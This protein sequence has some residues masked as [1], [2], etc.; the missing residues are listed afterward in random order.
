MLPTLPR[1]P[2]ATPA[3]DTRLNARTLRLSARSWISSDLTRV[4]PNWLQWVWTL[5]FSMMLAAVFTVIG[6]FSFGSERSGFGTLPSWA[7]W[8]GRNFVVCITI[9][10]FIHVLY[11]LIGQRIGGPAGLRRMSHNQRSLFF[12][13][14]PV[15]GLVVGW[16][17]GIWLSGSAELFGVLFGNMRALAG[18]VTLALGTSL[19]MHFYFGAKAKQLAAEQR[20]TEAQLRLLQGQM[21]P[22]FLFNTLAGVVALIDHDREAA[23]HTLLAFTD[24][25]RSSLGTLRRDEGTLAQELDLA[26]NYLKLMQARMEDRLRFRIEAEPAAHRVALPPL[27]LQPLVENAV[28][29][30]LEPSVNGGEIVIRARIEGPDLVLEV[31]DNGL[32]LDA[33][34]GS[35][36]R[37]GNGIALA[38]LR[39]RLLSRYGSAASLSVE[40]APPGTLSR[41][42]CPAEL[43]VIPAS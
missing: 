2:A 21:E 22:H 15:L 19:V 29:H 25:L 27:L 26:E 33:P 36:H 31:Q 5:L 42:R 38:N 7:G 23:K 13:G 1:M 14:V 34:R 30:G 10:G 3:R 8:Y 20:A 18:T 16:P 43:P 41:L 4:G 32:G 28:V 6:F 9:A 35:G 39:E 11:D 17:L 37:T 24:Y 12:G 40:A